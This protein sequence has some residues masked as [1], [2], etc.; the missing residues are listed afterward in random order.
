MDDTKGLSLLEFSR[1]WRFV[2][3][4]LKYIST[5]CLSM[6]FKFFPPPFAVRSVV[7]VFRRDVQLMK[8]EVSFFPSRI[9]SVNGTKLIN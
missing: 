9:N 5:F 4:T 2:S 3:S 7:F 6:A 1:K 8:P